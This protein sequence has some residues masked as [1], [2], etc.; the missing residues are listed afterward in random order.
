MDKMIIY[1]P[2]SLKGSV[3]VSGAK[4]AA[5]P[6][7]A[8]VLLSDGK[9]QITNVPNLKDIDTIL[10]LLSYL[11]VRIERKEGT[12]IADS[13]GIQ[14]FDA[15]YELVKTMRASILVLGPL[16][17]RFKRAKISL[18]GGCA[19]GERPINLHLMGLEKMGAS[20]RLEEGYVVAEAPR[21]YG[22]SIYFDIPTVT[23]TENLMMAATLAKGTTVLENVA[24]EPEVEDLANF[25]NKMGAKIFGVGT[26]KIVI[27]GVERL[28]AA[29]YSVMQDRIEAGTLLIAAA[30]TGG[31]VEIKH[32]NPQY[33]EAIIEKLRSAGAK[34]LTHQDSIFITS[35]GTFE[36]LQVQTQP[37]P[38]FPTDLQAQMMVLLTKAKGTSVMTETI[39]ENRFNHVAELRRMGADIRVDGRS[40]IIEGGAFL[41]GAPVMATDLRASASLIIAGLLAHGKTEIS[42]VY[43]LDRGY[44]ALHEKLLKLGAR[45]ERGNL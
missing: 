37:Y 10:A 39:F 17:T 40:A 25:L 3:L 32:S 41:S 30:A 44:E 24:R 34:I 14:R 11:G 18:P 26:D 36:K 12:V 15:P 31:E 19:I 5:L 2:T 28:E 23:G 4:N 9:N 6:I 45:I 7:L 27:E 20:I 1:G 13:Q 16:L 29:P 35:D 8:A 22:T 38:G 42:R 33:L 43:H 21:L